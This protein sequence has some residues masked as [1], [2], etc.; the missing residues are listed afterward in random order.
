M[1]AFEDLKSQ[2][3]DQKE[4]LAPKN[5]AKQIFETIAGIQKNQRGTNV[6]LSLTA[7]I[8]IAFFFY[9]SAFKFQTTMIGLLLMIGVLLLRIVLEV[10]SI[11]KLKNINPLTNASQ[12]KQ[13]IVEYYGFRKNVHFIITPI[14]VIAYGIGFYM[15]LPGF[16]VSLSAG[17]YTYIIASAIVVLVVLAFLVAKQIKQELKILRNLKQ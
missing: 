3:K 2:W 9:I 10:F 16:K 8:L 5:G 7:L 12:Y 17:F 15:L 4:V 14:I 1:E 11:R 6:I 13:Q